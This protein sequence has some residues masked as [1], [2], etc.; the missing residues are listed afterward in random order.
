ML[1]QVSQDPDR[2]KPGAPKKLWS[3]RDSLETRLRRSYGETSETIAQAI[4]FAPD[5]VRL[6]MKAEKLAPAKSVTERLALALALMA[7]TV[8]RETL[9]GAEFAPAQHRQRQE[10]RLLYQALHP[11]SGMGAHAQDKEGDMK[12]LKD[13]K[14][15]SDDDLR[16]YV[17]S[18]VSG[19]EAKTTPAS[20]P[21]SNGIHS[22]EPV[23]EERSRGTDPASDGDEMA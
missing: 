22:R 23:S 4:G 15:M 12:H 9:T 19:L 2:Q 6:H 14:E 18:L 5:T 8:A 7:D 16:A 13:I 20:E 11:A 10:L 3:Q 17:A 1:E 21:G